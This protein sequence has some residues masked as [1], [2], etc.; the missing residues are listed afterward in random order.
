MLFFNIFSS[1]PTKNIG[2]P[3]GKAPGNG[4]KTSFIS[5]DPEDQDQTL[6]V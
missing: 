2:V 6:N 4:E 1:I 3:L 5:E